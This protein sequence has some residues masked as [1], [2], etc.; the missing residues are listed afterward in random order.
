[1]ISL[2]G[3]RPQKNIT[4]GGMRLKN[5]KSRVNSLSIVSSLTFVNALKLND[6]DV[7]DAFGL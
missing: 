6:G 7:K 3:T 1:M 4:T 2:Y 5:C